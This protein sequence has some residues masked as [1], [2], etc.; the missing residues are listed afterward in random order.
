MLKP[1]QQQAIIE[2]IKKACRSDFNDFADV[3]PAA[4]AARKKQARGSFDDFCRLYLPTWFNSPVAAFQ[5]EVDAQLEKRDADIIVVAA[6]REHGKTVR[7]MKAYPLHEILF[8]KRR[9]IMVISDNEDIAEAITLEI[10]TL[11]ESNPR[12]I[13]DF[14]SLANP[15]KWESTEFVTKNGV[16]VRARGR[17]QPVRSGIFENYRP[18]LQLVDD[19]SDLDDC[20]NEVRERDKKEWV[21]GELYGGLAAHGSLLWLGNWM[22]KTSAIAQ[23]EQEAN[24][25]GRDIFY[26]RYQAIN[27]DGSLLWPERYDKAYMDKKISKVG[28]KIFLREWQQMDVDTGK[29]YS[30]DMFKP[31][32]ENEAIKLWAT[33]DKRL[34]YVD[35]GTSKKTRTAKSR[36]GD[37]KVAV[38]LGRVG[39][40]FYF[41]DAVSIQAAPALFGVELCKLYRKW[42]PP[43]VYYEGNFHQAD[44]IGDFLNSVSEREG[45]SLPK[46]PYNTSM[47]KDDRISKYSLDAQA[48]NIYANLDSQ[49]VVSVLENACNYPLVTFDDPADAFCTGLYVSEFATQTIKARVWR[50]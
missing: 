6:P 23:A 40:C 5:S 50:T 3:S 13:S 8:K 17:K 27:P 26:R 44:V 7:W 11:L 46:V 16:M 20:N 24:Q 37:M 45:L 29:Y 35:P 25:P 38:V 19:I 43:V 15:A 21:M 48:G 4:I 14:G 49:M 18:D 32:T 33:M 47:A 10:R 2:L 42:Q 1:A 41:F 22:R 31:F 34:I 39:R 28:L 30:M 12:I 9:F 36:G